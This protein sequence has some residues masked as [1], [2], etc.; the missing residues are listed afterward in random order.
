MTTSQR[1]YRGSPGVGGGPFPASFTPLVRYAIGSIPRSP[2][3]TLDAARSAGVLI[4]NEKEGKK[5]GESD[6]GGRRDKNEMD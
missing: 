6:D 4:K 3:E 5:A 1:Q 2:T